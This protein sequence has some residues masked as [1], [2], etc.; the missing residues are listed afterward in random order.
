MFPGSAIKASFG[1][2]LIHEI[3]LILRHSHTTGVLR[4][5]SGNGSTCKCSQRAMQTVPLS[6][7]A[8][9]WTSQP[10]YECSWTAQPNSRP[11]PVCR[12]LRTTP[13]L[14]A[15]RCTEHPRKPAC[16]CPSTHL[17]RSLFPHLRNSRHFLP[18]LPIP[19]QFITFLKESD[20]YVSCFESCCLTVS[21][22]AA[23]K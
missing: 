13:P 16:P 15:P 23:K 2:V 11:Q 4:D 21:V 19:Q 14:L 7:A 9:F 1:D 3:C 18:L 12:P 5:C 8:L 20:T 10:G 6:P 17:K 22:L